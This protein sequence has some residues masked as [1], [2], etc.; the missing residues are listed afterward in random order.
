MQV[1]LY[2]G[3]GVSNPRDP[4]GVSEEGGMRLLIFFLLYGM[5][6][7]TY[8]DSALSP[9]HPCCPSHPCLQWRSCTIVSQNEL[10]DSRGESDS[11]RKAFPATKLEVMLP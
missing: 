2:P 7:M 5:M 6:E 9:C 4:C 8:G 1:V 3:T 11:E 10:H